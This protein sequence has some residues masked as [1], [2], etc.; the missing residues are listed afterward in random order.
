VTINFVLLFYV[1]PLYIASKIREKKAYWEIPMAAQTFAVFT[2]L[3]VIISTAVG[4]LFYYMFGFEK[5][6]DK[7][8][9]IITPLVF[10]LSAIYPIYILFK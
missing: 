10:L 7:V 6:R 4:P 2:I 9:Y 5:N 1:L 8:G 3:L